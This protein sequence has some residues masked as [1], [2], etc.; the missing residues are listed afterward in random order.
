MNYEISN[1]VWDLDYNIDDWE[2]GL[3]KHFTIDI[4][5]NGQKGDMIY[6]C[7]ELE[8]YISDYAL[9]KYGYELWQFEFNPIINIS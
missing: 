2:L 1:I 9:E 7:S 5:T 4:P 3:P 8:K 6:T